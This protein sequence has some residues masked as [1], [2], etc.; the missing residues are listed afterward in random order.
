VPTR[1]MTE[2]PVMWGI[3]AVAGVGVGAGGLGRW[4]HPWGLQ[5]PGCR[6]EAV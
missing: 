1:K 3:P 6:Q 2:V 5:G 4:K